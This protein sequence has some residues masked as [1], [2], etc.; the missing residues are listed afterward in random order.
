MNKEIL[1]RS[2]IKRFARIRQVVP[3]VIDLINA[4]SLIN[5]LYLIDALSK[6]HFLMNAPSIKRPIKFLPA[7]CCNNYVN[8]SKMALYF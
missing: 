7:N 3:T 6:Q 5:A 4:H 8:L 1:K 2:K